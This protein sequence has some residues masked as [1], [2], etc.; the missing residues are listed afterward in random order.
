MN[1]GYSG[2]TG[3]AY[4]GPYL[5]RPTRGEKVT[6]AILLATIVILLF[7]S[8]IIFQVWWQVKTESGRAWLRDNLRYH[9]VTFP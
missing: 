8:G 6:L 9:H 1:T 2:P 5:P 4:T 3:P 7:L